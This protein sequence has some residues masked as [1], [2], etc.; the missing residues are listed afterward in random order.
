MSQLQAEVEQLKETLRKL[1]TGD[2]SSSSPPSSDGY[3]RKNKAIVPRQR[4]Q[5]PKYGDDG[6]T[7]NGFET[8]DHT[9]VAD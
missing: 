7:R 9:A 3:K 2:S 5:G 6:K 1:S 4:K 8:V